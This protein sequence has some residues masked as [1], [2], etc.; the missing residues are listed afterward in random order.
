MR[1]QGSLD[2]LSVLN[3]PL[4]PAAALRVVDPKHILYFSTAS[5]A[6]ALEWKADMMS[7]HQETRPNIPST[8]PQRQTH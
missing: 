5:A 3:V 4:S 7:V 1:C 8:P 6:E 2:W